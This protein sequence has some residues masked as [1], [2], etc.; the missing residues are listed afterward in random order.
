MSNFIETKYEVKN[1]ICA[2]TPLIIVDS[3]ERERIEKLL[4]EVSNELSISIA[5]YTDAKQVCSFTGDL[6]IDVNSDPLK[7][8]AGYFKKHR[9]STFAFGDVRRISDDN[10]YS[11][12]LLNLLYLAKETNCTLILITSDIIWPRLAQFGMLITL[13]YPDDNERKV[14]I[15]TFID[16]YKGKYE[17]DWYKHDVDRASMLLKGFTEIQIDNILSSTIITYKSLLSKHI[18]ELTSQ[19]R[20]LYSANT[21]VQMIEGNPDLEV[22]GL[23]NLKKWLDERRHI[24]FASDEELKRHE[25]STPKGILLAGVPGCGKSFS[26]KMVSKRWGLPLFRFDIG[27]V[28]NKW[29]GESEKR[30]QDAL[31]FIDNVSPCVL[32]VDEIEKAL[33]TASVGNDTGKRVLGQFLFWLQETKS[34]VFLVATANDVSLLPYELFRKGRFSELFFIDLPNEEE[35]REVIR[36]YSSRS[37]GISADEMDMDGLVTISEGFSYSDI[38]Y[39]IK[40]IA[41]MLLID[42]DMVVDSQLIKQKFKQVIPISK[43]NPEMI[44]EIR[45][46]GKQRAISASKKEVGKKDE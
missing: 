36:L 3:S 4:R 18:N 28:Y 17:I 2:R 30:M 12:E 42:P 33:A 15:K 38:E 23:E 41:Q 44:C 24:F 46:W 37:L 5:Y 9:N 21:N 25:L 39:I 45:E 1:Y 19:K 31:R 34:R 22:A 16:M 7:Y 26:A 35:R 29:V 32:W 40:D 10:M 14:L 11:W 13:D 20:R 8:I 27:T 43:S 6:S